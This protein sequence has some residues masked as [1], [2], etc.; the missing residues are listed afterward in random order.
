M[1]NR[2]LLSMWNYELLY[3]HLRIHYVSPFL[4]SSFMLPAQHTL[5]G[6]QEDTQ[7]FIAF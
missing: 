1:V 2:L 6:S 5:G 7:G 4:I 3:I